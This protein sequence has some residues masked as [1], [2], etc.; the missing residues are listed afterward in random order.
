MKLRLDSTPILPK[1]TLV[2]GVSGGRDS[3]ALLHALHEQRK[4]LTLI[5]AHVNHGLRSTAKRDA[6]FVQQ[7]AQE[8]KLPFELFSP[9]APRSGNLEEWG[10]KK[11][12]EFFAKVAEK[13]QAQCLVTAHHQD[14]DFESMLLHFLR[15]TRVKGLSG[16]SFA[17]AD[18]HPPLLRPLLYTSRAEID[19]YLSH[20]KIPYHDDPS[21]ENQSLARNFLRHQIIPSL[22]KAYPQAYPGLAER[23]QSQKDYWL[24][25][26][27]ML[28]TMARDFMQEFLD[29]NTGLSRTAYSKLPFPLRATVLELWY[30]DSTG[31]HVADS[32][33]LER[34]DKA[35]L[36]FTSGKKTEWNPTG[37]TGQRFLSLTKE[38][39]KLI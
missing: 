37:K 31:L 36:S 18:L 39:A 24:D 34:W 1:A 25:L 32:T 22:S 3:M 9:K 15:G 2:I 7:I 28:E 23:W 13:Y 5:V 14:D 29:E 12:Y 33:T 19:A 10:R 38:R 27:K 4:D 35:I 20:H 11:R 26:Q 16:M 8:W 17:R 30:Q 21:N 6:E